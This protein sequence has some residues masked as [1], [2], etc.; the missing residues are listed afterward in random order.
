VLGNSWDTPI[1]YVD[2]LVPPKAITECFQRLKKMF[3]LSLVL[4][5]NDAVRQFPIGMQRALHRGST[6]QR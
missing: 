4:T 5:V 2:S 1:P 6:Q 3:F